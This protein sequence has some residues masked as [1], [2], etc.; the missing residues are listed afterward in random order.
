LQDLKNKS[1]VGFR[2]ASW[3]FAPVFFDAVEKLGIDESQF[4]RMCIEKGFAAA[5]ATVGLERRKE[6][7]EMVR[8]R[9]KLERP[10]DWAAAGEV[11]A[12]YEKAIA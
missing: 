5:V 8:A 2:Y 10:F 6:M 3:S 4:A 11:A 7:K 1:H 9:R 12:D